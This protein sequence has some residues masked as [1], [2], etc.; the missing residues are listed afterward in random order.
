[1]ST[2]PYADRDGTPAY[3]NASG[4]RVP[5]LTGEML[6]A[7]LRNRAEALAYEATRLKAGGYIERRRE[8]D[9]IMRNRDWLEFLACEFR[10]L[11][12]RVVP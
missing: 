1:M 11:A 4:K 7:E 10:Q 6:A 12:D 5:L 9:S 2:P 8:K 3:V